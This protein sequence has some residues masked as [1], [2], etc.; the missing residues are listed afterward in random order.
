M[1]DRLTLRTRIADARDGPRLVTRSVKT[2]W[3]LTVTG[4]GEADMRRARSADAETVVLTVTVLPAITGSGPLADTVAV[5]TA[6]PLFRSAATMVTRPVAPAAR[7]PKSQVT[8]PLVAA[9]LP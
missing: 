2:N 1:S 7:L 6:V 8:T 4:S 3:L 5:L 9:Q